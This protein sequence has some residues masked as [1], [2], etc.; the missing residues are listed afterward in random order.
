M[1]DR[2]RNECART[3]IAMAVI[4]AAAV[5]TLWLDA[6]GLVWDLAH[7]SPSPEVATIVSPADAD[8][9]GIDDYA[10]LARGAELEAEARP[11][12]DDAY[13]QGGYP[14]EGRGACTDLVWRAFA[15]AGYDLK[16]MVDADVAAHPERY[17]HITASDPNIDFRRVSTLEAFFSAHAESLATSLDDPT[18][19]QPGDIVTF[20]GDRHV[21]ICS[22]QRD[23]RG[24]P[25]LCHNSGQLRRKED[26]LGRP[27]SMRISG[28]WRF[29]AKGVDPSVIRTWANPS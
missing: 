11:S 7:G 10:D 22:T 20:G 13:Y 28:H 5:A 19:W 2:R 24:I 17:P 4:C 26:Y 9:D 3:L 15:A 16:A 14:P 23:S 1:S 18:S 29:N 25:L 6:P 21:G 27:G 8:A 12:Y